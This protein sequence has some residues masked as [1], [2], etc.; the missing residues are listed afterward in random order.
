MDKKFK[1]SIK[2]YTKGTS[3]VTLRLPNELIDKINIICKQTK[4]TRNNIIIKSLD[5]ALNNI[6]IEEKRG[7]V[8]C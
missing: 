3:V 1:V 2:Q 8:I 6:E 4:R 5:F 7:D